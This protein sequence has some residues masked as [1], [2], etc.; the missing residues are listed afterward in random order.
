MAVDIKMS[1]VPAEPAAEATATCR[2]ALE[3]AVFK[4]NDEVDRLSGT[5]DT[6]VTGLVPLLMVMSVGD[7]VM[8]NWMS[9]ADT[10]LDNCTIDHVSYSPSPPPPK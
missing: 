4:E 1:F 10:C 2:V 7:D 3:V 8:G 9:L 5:I 6:D